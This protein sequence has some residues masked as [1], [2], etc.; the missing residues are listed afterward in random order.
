MIVC[1]HRR[2]IILKY[3]LLS[4]FLKRRD[5]DLSISGCTIHHIV[6]CEN[7]L[8]IPTSSDAAHAPQLAETKNMDICLSTRIACNTSTILALMTTFRSARVPYFFIRIRSDYSADH[9]SLHERHSLS[10][11]LYIAEIRHCPLLPTRTDLSN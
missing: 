5:S 7:C 6:V 1:S 10:I 11:L 4:L 2:S 9:A 8:D 3:H